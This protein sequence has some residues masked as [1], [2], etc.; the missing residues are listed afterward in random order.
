MKL[1]KLFFIFIILL[2]LGIFGAHNAELVPISFYPFDVE[3][4]VAVFLLFF[5]AVFIGVILSAFAYGTK[6]LHWRKLVRLKNREIERLEKENAA[7]RAEKTEITT[8]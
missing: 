3:L 4:S 5:G 6:V 7:L 8:I 1:I 2:M